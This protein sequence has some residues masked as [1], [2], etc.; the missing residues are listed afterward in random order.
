MIHGKKLENGDMAHFA[1][2][3]SDI[4]ISASTVAKVLIMAG[5]P[6]DEPIAHY[7][8]FVMNTQTEIIQAFADLN[9]GKMGVISDSF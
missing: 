3:G 4:S 1:R 9:A 5:R 8:P 2:S 7:G 6:L